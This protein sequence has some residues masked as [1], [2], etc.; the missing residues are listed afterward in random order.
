M[1]DK[2]IIEQQVD[3]LLDC[4]SNNSLINSIE[5]IVLKSFNNEFTI[6]LKY[7]DLNKTKSLVNF[8][9]FNNKYI[10]TLSENEQNKEYWILMS[11]ASILLGHVHSRQ[12]NSVFKHNH[13]E[14]L[15]FKEC[16]AFVECFNKKVKS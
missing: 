5:D 4:I 2:S 3:F 15:F 14:D 9:D 10:I 13:H 1:I 16:L 11:M 8:D 7:G 6:K 12:P